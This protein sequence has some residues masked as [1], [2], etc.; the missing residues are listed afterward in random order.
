MSK[1][2]SASRKLDPMRVAMA[3]QTYDAKKQMTIQM[4]N[5]RVKTD[6]EF[7]KLALQIGKDLPENIRKD[8][9]ETVD[10]NLKQMDSIKTT[11][12]IAQ[13]NVQAIERIMDEE[14]ISVIDSSLNK[15]KY[16]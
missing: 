16:E 8:A 4:V 14:L 15:D 1:L 7:A 12:N 13:D 5:D 6:V 3:I 2:K 11:G 9:Q 10:S